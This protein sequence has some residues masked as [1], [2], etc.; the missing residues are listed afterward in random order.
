MKSLYVVSVALGI[1]SGAPQSAKSQTSVNFTKVNDSPRVAAKVKFIDDIQIIND[2][3]KTGEPTP[4]DQWKMTAPKF[5]ETRFENENKKQPKQ[6]VLD[7]NFNDVEAT[8]NIFPTASSQGK[9]IEAYNKTQFKYAQIMDIDVESIVNPDLY[10]CIDKWYGTKYRYGG[11]TK[12]GVDCSALTGDLLRNAFNQNPERTARAQ[13]A[14]SKKI[15]FS[16]LQEGDLV[17]FNTT[18]GIS[19][20]GMYLNNGY[21][22]HASVHKG[23]TISSL[24]DGYYRSKFIGA[25]R[26]NQ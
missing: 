16:Q 24:N 20:V 21:F 8:V 7:V 10:I 5:D 15:N 13:Y 6:K 18:G 11:T 1:L 25:G 3:A 9:S 14:Q 12:K 17:F 22:V 23:V 2:S 4:I 26:F 19:H